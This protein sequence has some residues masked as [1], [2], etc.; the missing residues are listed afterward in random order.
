MKVSGFDIDTHKNYDLCKYGW[1]LTRDAV[2]GEPT[3]KRKNEFYLPMPAAMMLADAQNKPIQHTKSNET[4]NIG[5]FEQ[6]FG[7]TDNPNN[8]SNPAYKAYLTRAQFPDLTAFILRGLLGLALSDDPTVE[9]PKS[10]EYLLKYCTP[11]GMSLNELYAHCVSEVLTTGKVLTILDIDTKINK[12]II[13]PYIAESLVNWKTERTLNS[14]NSNPTVL[15][16]LEEQ[17]ISKDPLSS[18]YQLVLTVL[19]VKDN[20]YTVTKKSKDNNT[21][22]VIVIPSYKGKRI[23]ELPAKIIG[24]ISNTFSKQTTPLYA[25][26]STSIQIYMKNADLANSEFMSCSP[27]LVISGVEA[28]FTPKAV[29]SSVALILPD[30]DSK[31]YY[32][33]TDTSALTHVLAHITD[34]YEQAIYSGAQLL[35][36]SKKAAESAETVRL[37]Q[38][39]S[40]ATL[41]SIVRNAGNV[42]EDQ[43]K[44]IATWMGENPDEVSFLPITDFLAPSLSAQEIT[45][46]VKSWVDKAISH[47]TLL[48][49]FRKAG[50]L[51]DGSS[52]EDEVK[53]V[54][55]DM[56]NQPNEDK[57]NEDKQNQP[58]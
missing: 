14:S 29:G 5:I 13:V 42:I 11:S 41:A 7:G 47:E 37:K 54:L 21:P 10:M 43:L 15:A 22:D 4:M 52:V 44:D 28:E 20:I 56:K 50:L 36:S 58:E 39:G 27:T 8:H 45:A 51:Q 24:S 16:L 48:D 35:D 32:T 25:V 17:D 30:S 31:A 40:G 9:L 49:N 38:T 18:D 23:L 2:D 57:S 46:L 12:P 26:A 6:Y 33:K 34:L 19:S 53:R 55:E 3:V 1:T